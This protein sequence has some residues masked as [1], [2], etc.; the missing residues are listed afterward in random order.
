MLIPAILRPQHLPRTVLACL[1][2][3]VLACLAHPA[4]FAAQKD[5]TDKE[6]K[7]EEKKEKIEPWVEV[8]TAHFVVASDGGEKEARHVADQFELLIRVFQATMPNARLNRGIPIQILA[9]KDGPSFAR[10]FPEFPFDKKRPQPPGLFVDGPEMTFIGIRANASGPDPFYDIYRDYSHVVL[11]LSYRNSPPWLELGYSDVYGSLVLGDREARMG[12]PDPDDMS[13]LFESPHLPIELIFHVDQDSPYYSP[14]DK[15]T[16]YSAESRALTYFLLTDPQIAGSKAMQQY[17]SQVEGGADSLAAARQAFGDLNQ[18]Q[19]RFEAYIKATKMPPSL[20]ASAGAGDSTGPAKTLSAAASEARMGNFEAARGRREDAEDKLEAALQQDSSIEEAEQG[21]GFLSLEEKELDEAE[22]HFT[23]ASELD[24]NDALNYYG[25]GMIAM[26]RGGFVGVPVG[27]VVA[28]EK[29]ITL[30]PN[31]A[32][33]WFNLA[34]I[35]ALRPETMQKALEDARRA[36]SLDP[37]DTSYQRQVT[38]ISDD[39][40]RNES[41]RHIPAEAKSTSNDSKPAEKSGESLGQTTQRQSPAPGISTNSA[42]P[43][44]T[45]ASP[46]VERKTASA[47]PKSVP[48]ASASRSEPSPAPPPPLDFSLARVYSMLGTITDVNCKEAPQIQLTLKSLTIVMKLHA[49]DF[50]QVAVKSAGS[51]DPIKNTAC[52]SLRGRSA[53]IS[54]TL[55]LNQDWD[56]EIKSIEFR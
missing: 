41:A 19:A 13:T 40:S 50:G 27:A 11:K 43:P 33:A 37:G 54:Y 53:H 34:S 2:L 14:G 4:A 49:D 24:P 16:M 28:F 31:F 17:V 12:R 45:P 22:K 6:N 47:E 23:R 52:A 35:Y 7:K 8:R 15:S 51:G 30:N 20:I 18:L 26:T 21:L 42:P 9:A 46:N 48:A 38:N 32:P 1:A 36:A 10:L 56:G 39:L 3:C 29:V 44:P 55:V 5:K 25:Q